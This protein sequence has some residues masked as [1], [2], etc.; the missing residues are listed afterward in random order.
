[1]A[2]RLRF[3]KSGPFTSGDILR[4]LF[5]NLALVQQKEVMCAILAITR[6]L[7]RQQ[8]ILEKFLI[9]LLT[10]TIPTAKVVQTA[11]DILEFTRKKG[12]FQLTEAD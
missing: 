6:N 7:P 11:F 2:E 5:N 8:G 12:Q 4:I 1:M 3:V 10:D 9:S